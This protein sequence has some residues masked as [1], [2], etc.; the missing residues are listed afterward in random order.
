MVFWELMFPEDEN[1]TYECPSCNRVIRGNEK[2]PWINKR[3]NIFKCP[4]C[5]ELLQIDS[6][7]GE[8]PFIGRKKRVM[9]IEDLVAYVQHVIESRI[10]VTPLIL[11]RN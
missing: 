2:V 8:S 11:L 9:N 3:G 1:K 7:S 10:F 5:D 6:H 4:Q